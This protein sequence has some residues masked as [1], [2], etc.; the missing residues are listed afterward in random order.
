MQIQNPS[1][2]TVANNYYKNVTILKDKKIFYFFSEQSNITIRN[3]T[4]LGN[5][6]DDLYTIGAA[7]NVF[8]E[9]FTVTDNVNTGAITETSAIL[10]VSTASEAC[11][12]SRFNVYTS[13]FKYGKAIEIEQAKILKFADS[14]YSANSL[15]NQDF[16]VF[17][18]IVQSEIKN[19]AFDS[20]TKISDK[21][22]F[23]LSLP[24][25]TLVPDFSYHS[26]SNITFMNSLSSFLSVSQVQTSST[27]VQPLTKP[28]TFQ[29]SDCVIMANSLSSKDP[30]FEFGEINY[31]NF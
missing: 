27:S 21:S 10:R 19:L 23:A 20:F 8:V 16:F 9:D 13:S 7:K 31:Q 24:T 6:L 1:K 29:I 5:T 11:V 4:L 26:V 3:E 2:V 15:Q 22:R 17:N 18:Q 28:Y 25:L 30:I 12:I 14:D